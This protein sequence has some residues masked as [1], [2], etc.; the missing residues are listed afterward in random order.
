M[1]AVASR[2]RREAGELA[3]L[4]ADQD[5]ILSGAER[6]AALAA[7]LRAAGV[8][9]GELE[10]LLHVAAVGFRAAVSDATASVYGARVAALDARLL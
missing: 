4:R 7:V 5:E 2:L 3:R 8:L 10:G 1:T 6:A 9:D